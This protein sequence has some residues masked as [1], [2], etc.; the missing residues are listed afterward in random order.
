MIDC[1]GRVVKH[2]PA[3]PA[4]LTFLSENNIN[5]SVAS[6]NAV[7]EGAEKLLHLFGWDEYFQNIQIYVGKKINHIMR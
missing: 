6:R 3:I 2:Y 7:T 5:I 1:R 4:I